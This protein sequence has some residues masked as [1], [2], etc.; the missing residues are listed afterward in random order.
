MSDSPMPSR[1]SLVLECVR[2][3][4]LR[5]SAGEWQ[6]LMP[7]ERKLADTLQVG[8]DTVR[9][10]LQQLERAGLLAPADAGNRR[11]IL[12]D[13]TG[14]ERHRSGSLKIG[15]LVH[16]ALESLPQPMLLEIDRIRGA[17]AAKGGALRIH[18]PAWYGQRNPSKRLE[19]L[20]EEEQCSAW[21]LL[22]SSAAVQQWFMN[23]QVPC[24]VRGYPQPDIE[25]P[26]LDVDWYATARHAAGQL[27]RLGHRKVIILRPAELLKGVEAAVA[28]AMDLGEPGFEA[29]ALV[30]DGTPLGIGRLLARALNYE[31][32]PTAIITTR[33]RQAASALTWL[34]SQG[35][36]VPQH[37]SLI[38]L[39]WEPFLDHLVPEISGYRTDAEAAAKLVVRRTERIA[40]GDPN[41]GGNLW[42]TQE[43]VKGASI[44][45][46]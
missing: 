19:E 41:P 44:G 1:G 31:D 20:V 26:H 25:L 42:I 38:T 40:A 9:L 35:V 10:A 45:K 7:G 13:A 14:G 43:I 11:R 15:L 32:P 27:W 3:M 46:L 16:R 22:R 30:E 21:I 12:T 34:A 8:R 5:I 4:E 2:V 29:A 6:R 23:R 17:L 37:I 24:L 28:G 18:S 39:A 36:R 33:A